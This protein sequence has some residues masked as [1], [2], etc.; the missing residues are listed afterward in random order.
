MALGKGNSLKSDYM[1]GSL[2]E[3]GDPMESMGNLMD[4]MLVFAC[5]LMVA[6]VA[7]YN[8]NL[9][10]S[11]DL[12]G[13][14]EE[15]NESLEEVAEGIANDSTAYAE[16]GSVYR[17]IETGQLYIVTPEGEELP[18]QAG[19]DGAGEGDAGGGAAGSGSASGSSESAGA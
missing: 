10:A 5:G 9:N 8:V 13:N 7:H 11:P 12:K 19:E 2:G 4:V 6:L 15:L 17:D 1:D 18:A 14:L 3:G 16:V